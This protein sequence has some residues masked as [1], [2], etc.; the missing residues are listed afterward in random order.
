MKALLLLVIVALVQATI[1]EPKC[2]PSSPGLPSATQI[3]PFY[4]YNFAMPANNAPAAGIFISVNDPAQ[5]NLGFWFRGTSASSAGVDVGDLNV[6][7]TKS[8][9]GTKNDTTWAT[10]SL[11]TGS[12]TQAT[13][14]GLPSSQ[15]NI[16]V[17]DQI[18]LTFFPSCSTCGSTIDFAVETAWTLP[19]TTNSYTWIPIQ[20]NFRTMVFNQ[21]QGN[22][23]YFYTN[24]TSPTSFWTDVSF[25]SESNNLNTQIILYFNQG[26]PANVSNNVGIYPIPGGP[27]QKGA[28]LTQSPFNATSAGTWFLSTYVSTGATISPTDFTIK[29]GLNQVPCSKASIVSFSALGLLLQ[30]LPFVWN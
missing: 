1:T 11:A 15:F 28:Y 21:N 20:N 16:S 26:S 24:V 25:T 9:L 17:G 27:V 23:L 8:R 6:A 5:A 3:W 22:W 18:W 13:T 7:L 30:L 14:F 2:P 29:V 19:G 4:K 12:C 10:C